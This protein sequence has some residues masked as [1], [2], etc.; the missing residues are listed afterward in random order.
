VIIETTDNRKYD[1][2]DNHRDAQFLIS[3]IS[4]CD[5]TQEAALIAPTLR[6]DNLIDIAL[7]ENKLYLVKAML[8]Y[9]K[10]HHPNQYDNY[11]QSNCNEWGAYLID[12]M[13]SSQNNQYT[14]AVMSVYFDL[15]KEHHL[16]SDGKY[17]GQNILQTLSA[18]L[19]LHEASRDGEKY[20]KIFSMLNQIS[21][22]FD[23]ILDDFVNQ[24]YFMK[25]FSSILL[26]YTQYMNLEGNGYHRFNPTMAKNMTQ[27]I[28]E[29][30]DKT[31]EKLDKK[32]FDLI[33]QKLNDSTEEKPENDKPITYD[34][35]VKMGALF[36][37][38][39]MDKVFSNQEKLINYSSQKK[40]K[41]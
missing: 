25:D 26:H 22:K 16:F 11:C 13:K 14:M 9:L 12:L 30:L 20:D 27:N 38:H 35:K 21:N 41:I 15:S 32:R 8:N 3:L 34:A 39:K 5:L 23:N 29:F 19:P 18:E 28:L 24:P 40:M 4:S 36:E 6:Q 10:E 31:F 2:R 17:R 33:Y 37:K 1:V 7:A